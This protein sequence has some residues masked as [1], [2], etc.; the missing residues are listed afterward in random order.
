MESVTICSHWFNLV[1]MVFLIQQIHKKWYTICWKLYQMH[2]HH[3]SQLHVM[4]ILVWMVNYFPNPNIWSIW[5]QRQIV[6]GRKIAA[7]KS[8]CYDMHN[9]TSVS[10][11]FLWIFSEYTNNYLHYKPSTKGITEIS[12]MHNW[13]IS[14]LYHKRLEIKT[15]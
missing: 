14:W 11:C 10:L 4:G 3:S 1:I 13:L 5:K 9:C 2:T 15:E 7:K 12:Y 6:I 8:R